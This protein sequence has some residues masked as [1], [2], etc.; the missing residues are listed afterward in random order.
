MPLPAPVTMAIRRD[1]ATAASAVQRELLEGVT[2]GRRETAADGER[3]GDLA[4][5]DVA[6]R[7]HGEAVRGGEA[8]RHAGVRAAPPR[9][10]ASVPV[11]DADTTVP[12]LLDRSM[13][14][15]RLAL[16][17]PQLGDVGAA[18][19]V[20]HEVRGA[21]GVRPLREVLA[22]GA[23]DL[24][25][26][27]LAVADEDAAIRVDGDA[28]RQVEL[29]RPGARYAP[30][31]LELAGRREAMHPTVAVPIGDI[32][33]APRTDGQIRGPVE[34]ARGS[35]DRHVVLAVVPR[36]GRRV[37]GPERR[38]QLAVGRELPHRVVAVVRA[39]DHVVR[40]DGDAVRA[41]GELALAPGPEEVA[42]LVVDDDGVV[43][44]ADQ[45]DPILGIDGDPR[46][47][48]VLVAGGKLLPALDDL[49]A[50]RLC[51]RH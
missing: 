50:Q 36:I 21:L 12:R 47:V 5:V 51:L 40:A 10:H 43:T 16:V 28:M 4:H 26:I 41:V 1:D 17:P 23:E 33:V 11:V 3:P 35:S 13:A 39:V 22:L 45:I 38:E 29:A 32:E 9:E 14:T 18:L 20:E 49:I 15:R 19:R 42:G 31:L 30:G 44:A 27:V 8:A 7:V 25:A 34:R 46:D 6:A 2:A 24:D 48:A 37:Q